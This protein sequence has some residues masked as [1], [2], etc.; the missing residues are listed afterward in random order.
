MIDEIW[1]HEDEH[2][3]AERIDEAHADNPRLTAWLAEQRRSFD[4]WS[5]RHGGGVGLQ[6]ALPRPRGGSR[7]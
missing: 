3:V 5:H 6:R 2:A 4:G 1:E 7:T